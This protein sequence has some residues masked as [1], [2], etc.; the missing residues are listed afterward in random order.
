MNGD[1]NRRRSGQPSTQLPNCIT[2]CRIAGAVLI[3]FTE[4]FSVIFF[5]LYLFCGITDVLD[6]WIA[7]R[8]RA[9][10]DFGALLDSIADFVFLIAV[11]WT[12]LPAISL[13]RWMIWW[14]G[15]IA[16]LRFI[17]L[18]TAL[19]RFG[20]FAWLHTIGNK[21]TGLLLF[22]SPVLCRLIGMT[23]TVLA[24]GAVA[25][26]SALEELALL[27]ILPQLD[28]D[29]KSFFEGG[30]SMKQ[31]M[32]THSRYDRARKFQIFWSLF[33]GI[34]AVAGSIGMGIR[35]DGSAIGMD[36]LLPYFQVLPFSELLFQNFIFPSIALFCVN[37]L[38][39][40]IAAYLQ[41]QKKKSGSI[42]GGVLG[43]T[44]M[45]WICI[46]F[47][48]F[49]ANFMSTSFFFFG[50]AQA[51]TGYAAV[52]FWKQEHFA[53][54]PENYPRIGTDPKRLVVYFSRMG[55][56]R[57]AAFE[58]AQKTGAQLYE[59]KAAERTTGTL[60]FWWC[61]RYG[62]H[63]LAMPIEPL[64]IDLAAF[65][66]VTLCSPIWVFHLAAPMRQFCKQ[67]RGKIKTADYILT[68]HMH[69]GFANAAREM[70]AL[71][72]LK[73]SSAIS[74]TCPLGEEKDV[75]LLHEENAIV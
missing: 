11:A 75:A 73:H 15:G 61:G 25:T 28:R 50:L 45:L 58:A 59:V 17:S 70:D 18:A 34:G 19:C 5:A 33:I 36:A 60:G 20:T 14:A 53:V 31:P 37:G 47:V 52:V 2:L 1:Q 43:V 26:L 42:L 23:P 74:I 29:R 51:L 41:L 63:R 40:L 48:I 38:P 54:C 12:V 69:A 62:M 56:T 49:P 35:P 64:S 68:H 16:A 57:K 32:K 10:S 6:G 13:A 8:L 27:F 46:Q 21:C 71:L 22:S 4:P 72:G 39:N 9:E 55:Y 7:R 65:D 66:H 30:K 44:L 67:A 3:V 24:L